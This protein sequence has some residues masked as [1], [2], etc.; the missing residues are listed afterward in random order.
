MND[1]QSPGKFYP[2]TGFGYDVHRLV[3]G[4]KLVLGGVEIDFHLG[5]DGHSDADV[6]THAICDALL[7]AAGLGDIGKHFPDTDPAYSGISSIML[8]E[9]VVRNIGSLG[10]HTGNID[11][12]LVAQAPKLAPY[13]EEIRH[14]IAATC[15]VMPDRINIK[16]TTTEGLGFAG[17]G[18]GM[19]AYAVATIFYDDSH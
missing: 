2:R 19:A 12:T 18:K 14:R 1:Y 3:E 5:L 8:L 6:L 15:G 10:Y 7:G 16:A 9:T 17:L 4:R 13:M 11:A